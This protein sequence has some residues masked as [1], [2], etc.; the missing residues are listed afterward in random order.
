VIFP[1]I[2]QNKDFE[3]Y[4]SYFINFP[5]DG[6][7]T[8]CKWNQITKVFGF[9]NFETNFCTYAL[10]RGFCGLINAVKAKEILSKEQAATYLIR[11]SRLRPEVLT[12]S[13]K[14]KKG[15]IRHVRNQ[16]NSSGEP[17]E[18]GMFLKQ[19]FAE[20]VPTA[21]GLD[22]SVI[23]ANSRS[24]QAMCFLETYPLR[25]YGY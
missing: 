6:M 15:E 4:L 23:A 3:V 11:F 20:Y 5:D 7:M 16:E 9:K 21:L 19:M 12:V 2:K 17:V 24:L 13:C 25:L 22:E 10:G 18:I 14:N 8:T 1:S